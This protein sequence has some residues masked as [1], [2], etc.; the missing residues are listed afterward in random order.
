MLF[1]RITIVI[2]SKLQAPVY[3]EAKRYQKL[4]RSTL[5]LVPLFGIHYALFLGMSYFIE[6]HTLMELIYLILDQLFASFQVII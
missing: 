1:V 3:E 6:K 2:F 4:A 5:V